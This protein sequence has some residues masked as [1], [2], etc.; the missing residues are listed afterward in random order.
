[1]TGSRNM[2]KISDSI[3]FR[4]ALNAVLI[5]LLLLA[6]LLNLSVFTDYRS[7]A[8]VSG[9]MEPTL[10]YGSMVVVRPQA[11]YEPGDIVTFRSTGSGEVK[12]FTHRIVSIDGDLAETKGDANNSIDPEPVALSRAEGKVILTVPYAGYLVMAF[13]RQAVKIGAVALV[14]LWLAFELE[15]ARRRR[16]GRKD[17]DPGEKDRRTTE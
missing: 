9:S 15:F 12:R 11:Q 10:P 13:D 17:G 1:M 7:L 16:T 8:V 4:A 5:V 3:V 2:K 6:L 14:I